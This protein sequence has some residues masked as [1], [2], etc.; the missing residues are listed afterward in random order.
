M[1]PVL[2]YGSEIWTISSRMRRRLEATE[3]WFYRRMLR[4]SWTQHVSNY[5][6]LRRMQTKRRLMLDIRKRQLKFLGHIMRKK[7]LKNLILTGRIEEGRD[8]GKKRP[9]YLNGLSEW[10]T[11]KGIGEA[12][13]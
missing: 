1:I 10:M 4:I 2:L 9:T 7:G 8:R 12:G 11:G 6:V 5:E 13:S 3:M